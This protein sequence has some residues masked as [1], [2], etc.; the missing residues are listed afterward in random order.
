MLFLKFGFSYQS[1]ADS[2]PKKRHKPSEEETKE[3]N[4][5]IYEKE[6]QKQP[7]Q[8]S[9]CCRR[10]LVADRKSA[11]VIGSRNFKITWWSQMRRVVYCVTVYVTV[12]LCVL[13]F[14]LL[15]YTCK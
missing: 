15:L 5:M 11:L 2:L 8:Q 6:S 1:G 13:L 9:W 4:T 10:S 3:K 14:S 12:S 7:F